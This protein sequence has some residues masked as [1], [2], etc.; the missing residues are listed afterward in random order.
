MKRS[1]QSRKWLIFKLSLIFGGLTLINNSSQAIHTPGYIIDAKSDTIYG[2]VQLS[3]LNQITGGYTLNG[4]ELESFH[5]KV[6]FKSNSENRYKTYF[7]EMI[8]GFGF[9][10]KSTNY[11]FRQ[12][13]VNHTSLIARESQQ[14]RFLCLI[15]KGSYELYKDLSFVANPYIFRTEQFL[16]YS[17]YFLYSASKGLIKIEKNKELKSLRDLFIHADTDEKFTHTIPENLSFKYTN[18]LLIV[19]DRWLSRRK[20]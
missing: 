20:G 12:F 16:S 17:D 15:Y 3:R 13:T 2:T 14:Q 11:F 6:T 4:I 10:Y 9:S 19:Y 7:P 1:F 8:L 5:T 18:S